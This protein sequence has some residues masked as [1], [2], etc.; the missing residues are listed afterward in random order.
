[1]PFH[2][3]DSE[4]R[5]QLV[6]ERPANVAVSRRAAALLQR[7]RTSGTART[8][9]T[10]E[11][12]TMRTRETAPFETADVAHRSL[13]DSSVQ[14]IRAARAVGVA[15]IALGIAAIVVPFVAGVAV[16]Y[17]VATALLFGSIAL[18]GLAIGGEHTMGQRVVGGLAALVLLLGGIMMM[19]QPVLGLFSLTAAVAAYLFAAGF[20][21]IMAALMSL[22]APSG[23]WLLVASGVI[24]VVLGV[25]L[26]RQWPLSG[27]WA[28]GTLVGVDLVISG[29]AVI[30]TGRR[31]RRV[32]EG[33]ERIEHTVRAP[34]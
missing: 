14:A 1:V 7:M 13:G 2:T 18:F 29:G 9:P 4:R 10:T 6:G 17:L 32:L 34:E 20:A 24:A 23:R 26:L 30:A 33:V 8:R 19:V 28:I 16:T 21:R 15:L 12:N 25:L 11:V 3:P 31:W 22:G 5:S 27:T